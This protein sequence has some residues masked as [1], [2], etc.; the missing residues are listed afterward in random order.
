MRGHCD[1]CVE[2]SECMGFP[3]RMRDGWWVCSGGSD[4]ERVNIHLVSPT[5]LKSLELGRTLDLCSNGAQLMNSPNQTWNLQLYA[6][7]G[8]SGV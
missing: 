7:A 2:S 3:R 6:R 4:S 1:A 5:S 8:F